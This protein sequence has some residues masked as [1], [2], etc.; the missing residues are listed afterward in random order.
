M[1]LL[2]QKSD[3]NSIVKVMSVMMFGAEALGYF[4]GAYDLPPSVLQASWPSEELMTMLKGCLRVDEKRRWNSAQ[5]RDCAW[6][7]VG[8]EGAEQLS[9]GSVLTTQTRKC[10]QE[11]EWHIMDMTGHE[12]KVGKMR[13]PTECCYADPISE[14]V[15]AKRYQLVAGEDPKLSMVQDLPEALGNALL[16][17]ARTLGMRYYPS[18]GQFIYI[19][20]GEQEIEALLSTFPD[21][22]VEDLGLHPERVSP[23]S[24]MSPAPAGPE[25]L[26]FMV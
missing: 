24:P 10:L 17:R 20:I 1:S 9:A 4:D 16:A 26:V 23:R 14:G 13:V 2:Q 6:L 25:Q 22:A 21:G 3:V 15:M 5:L 19:E 7:K 12:C 18:H 8:G 11:S